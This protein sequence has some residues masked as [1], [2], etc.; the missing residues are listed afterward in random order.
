MS[1]KRRFGVSIP[2]DLAEDLDRLANMIG[3]DRSSIVAEALKTYIHDHLYCV[4]RHKCLG[5]IIAV[6][7]LNKSPREK[8][9]IDEFKDIIKSYNH[10]HI[11]NNCIEIFIVE[12]DSE[13]ISKLHSKLRRQTPYVR[14]IPLASRLER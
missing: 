3:G 8:L 1:C 2:V 6:T 4:H 9:W 7:P 14:Y 11:E 13:R 10:Q 12:G 5:I